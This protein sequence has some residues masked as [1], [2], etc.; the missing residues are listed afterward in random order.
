MI[1][2]NQNRGKVVALAIILAMIP[3]TSGNSRGA[4]LPFLKLSDVL[5]LALFVYLVFQ[6]KGSTKLIDSIGISILIYVVI[7]TSTSVININERTDITGG[8]LFK[9]L[10]TFPQYLLTYLISFWVSQKEILE[11]K[12]LKYSMRISVLISIVAIIQFLDLFDMRQ[13]LALYTGNPKRQT[14]PIGKLTVPHLC[15]ILG[16]L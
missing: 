1:K 16:M 4:V 2:D 8:V 13:I 11:A 10:L 6:F 12:F 5:T 15:S 9:S 3:A 7:G 14:S